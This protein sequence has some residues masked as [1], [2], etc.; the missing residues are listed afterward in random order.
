MINP[1]AARR[2]GCVLMPTGS[3]A[4]DPFFPD[5]HRS[6]RRPEDIDR[7]PTPLPLSAAAT[8]TL[9]IQAE[10]NTISASFPVLEGVLWC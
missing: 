6:T 1:I 3:G 5:A 9:P 2:T 4:S 10:T 8:S 7:T